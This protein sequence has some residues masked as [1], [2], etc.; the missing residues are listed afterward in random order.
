MTQTNSPQDDSLVETL[1]GEPPHFN[2]LTSHS[3]TTSIDSEEVGPLQTPF[4]KQRKCENSKKNAVKQHQNEEQLSEQKESL[5]WKSEMNS[6]YLL[7]SKHKTEQ[8]T[9]RRSKSSQLRIEERNTKSH[10]T[11]EFQ[12]K[13]KLSSL[14]E[15]CHKQQLHSFHASFQLLKESD[16]ISLLPEEIFLK[17]LRYLTGTLSLK[18]RFFHNKI[19]VFI[20]LKKMM[21]E[22]RFILISGL[23]EEL[24]RCASVSKLWLRLTSDDSLWKV[25]SFRCSFF[26]FV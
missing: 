23:D 22:I 12:Y 26:F 2:G 9:S 4:E 3:N 1:S 6:N 10:H 11:P 18:I 8:K 25:F 20:F 5:E 24:C 7:V 14:P 16:I 17:I 19:I 15:S 21:N 13:S